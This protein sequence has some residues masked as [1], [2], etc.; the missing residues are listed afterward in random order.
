MN[1]KERLSRLEMSALDLARY[2]N[3][4]ENRVGYSAITR[5][6]NHP[7]IGSKKTLNIIRNALDELEGK[8]Y[9]R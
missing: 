9:G 2:I 6:I 1:F 7:T 8:Q 5:C 4:E 3:R